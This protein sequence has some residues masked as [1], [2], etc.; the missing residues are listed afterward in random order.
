MRNV[1]KKNSQNTINLIHIF[2]YTSKRVQPQRR[3]HQ[4]E[5]FMTGLWISYKKLSQVFNFSCIIYVYQLLFL[6]RSVEIITSWTP[7]SKL[8]IGL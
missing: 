8:N 4:S 7:C 5:Y 1:E 6:Y 3:F 2:K